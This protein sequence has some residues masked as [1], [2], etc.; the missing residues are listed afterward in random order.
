MGRFASS[1][2]FEN[3]FYQVLMPSRP[4]YS[5]SAET[6][7]LWF[8]EI[9]WHEQFYDVIRAFKYKSQPRK[10]TWIPSITNSFQ[11]A[12]NYFYFLLYLLLSF[13]THSY[14]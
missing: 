9:R 14:F 10:A 3:V 4:E 13:V 8:A 5:Q 1:S 6:R 11:G 2:N 12:K 7:K